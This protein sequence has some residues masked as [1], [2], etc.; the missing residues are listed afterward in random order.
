[1]SNAQQLSGL[2][3]TFL[4]SLGVLAAGQKDQFQAS[5]YNAL[6]QATPLVLNM[7]VNQLGL[8]RLPPELQKSVA[9]IPN[10]VDKLLRAAVSKLAAKV[11]NAAIGG[12]T[13][14]GL[15]DGKVAAERTFTYNGQSYVL[16]VAQQAG[17]TKVK[18]AQKVNGN[19]QFVNGDGVLTAAS[20]D[21]SISPN[22]KNDLNAL[23]GT[24]Q[25]LYQATKQKTA[26]KNAILN[27]RQL[28]QAV[29]NAE[30]VVVKDILANACTALNA[31]CF[32]AGTKLLMRTGWK[33][34]E[35][36]AA[37]DEVA[38]RHESDPAGEVQWKPVEATFRRTGRILHLHFPDGE[39]IRTTPEHPFFVPGEGWIPA[40]SLKDGDR[41]ATLTGDWVT[42]AEVYDT[43]VWEVVYNIRVADFH[44][45]FVGDDGWSFAA[46][47]IMS[48]VGMS[49]RLSKPS[50]KSRSQQ[51]M[52]LWPPISLRRRTGRAS[53][54]SSL[55]SARES[56][57]APRAKL[58]R[59][60]SP[61]RASLQL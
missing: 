53:M 18:V 10:Q 17:K 33:V 13:S 39:L 52:P 3:Q 30:D 32:A 19:Y 59:L 60:S 16:W 12:G 22:A 58:Q 47:R 25:S 34:V 23:A 57:L 14:G 5:V 15:F 1:M 24:A 49:K 54:R 50:G 2:V 6:K 4:N 37:G 46:W 41:I 31:G 7:A 38:S 29:T 20:F 61:R 21:T 56:R 48:L 27:L 51:R 28:Q 45:Y 26:A 8:A 9:L 11:R 36:I 55:K 44:T 40:G 42:I 35:E 43:Q